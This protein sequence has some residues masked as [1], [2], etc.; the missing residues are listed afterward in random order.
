MFVSSVDLPIETESPITSPREKDIRFGSYSPSAGTSKDRPTTA[1]N[2]R[3]VRFAD[4]LG[5]DDLDMS[6][7]D[8][9]SRPSTAPESGRSKTKKSVKK[10]KDASLED[11]NTD[12]SLELSTG[13]LKK[14][15]K[16]KEATPMRK[17][18]ETEKSGIL[19]L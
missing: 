16:S 13:D 6:F 12:V 15:P 3:S 1:P 8:S 19:I 17:Q 18:K 9:T 2:R 14:T 4:E 7:P 5:F 10:S 11:D